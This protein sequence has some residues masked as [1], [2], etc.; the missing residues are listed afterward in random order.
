MEE[1]Q[2]ITSAKEEPIVENS[3]NA[4]NQS[5]EISPK[6]NEGQSLQD[7]SSL[8]LGKFKTQDDL[9]N[10]YKQLEKLQGSQSAEL[11]TLRQNAVWMKDI[12]KAWKARAELMNCA[13]ELKN[14]AKKYDTP[15]YFQDPSFQTMFKEAYLALG[16]K[17]DTDRFVNLLEGYVSSRIMKYQQEQ[18]A[19]SETR[20]AINGMKFDKNKTT[21]IK[22]SGKR[23][24]EMTTEEINDI[25]DRLI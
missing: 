8:I 25:L 21:D 15:E 18:A 16:R 12:Q 17:L 20:G 5:S 3:S 24:D 4:E 22:P 19:Q 7:P 14:A 1:N 23:I 11:G 6:V 10:A 2:N 13:E 9:I